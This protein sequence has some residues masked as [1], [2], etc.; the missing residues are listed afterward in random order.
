MIIRWSWSQFFIQIVQLAGCTSR[1]ISDV[2]SCHGSHLP[3][4]NC[5]SSLSFASSTPVSTMR[6]V[7]SVA[8]DSCLQRLLTTQTP[9]VLHFRCCGL[10]CC[11]AA[12]RLGIRLTVGLG[13]VGYVVYSASFLAYNYTGNEQFVV[14][15][16]SLLGVCA[17]LLWTAQATVML[18]YPDELSKG[19]H[20]SWF[21][22]IFN[23][24]A[25][26]GGLVH[27]VN[28]MDPW[29]KTNL[30]TDSTHCQLQYRHR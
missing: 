9:P 1:S 6:L 14:F 16:G 17:G 19:K 5:F 15:S 30:K 4:F 22:S 21:W 25:V 8:L 18:S 7:A 24:G 13:G 28:L 12:N 26:I 27:S 10:L 11:S 23:L 29:S 20:I 2:F 3:R